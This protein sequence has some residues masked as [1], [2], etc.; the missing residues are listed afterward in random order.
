MP[1][2][3]DEDPQTEPRRLSV[4]PPPQPQQGFVPD[5][6]EFV[7]DPEPPQTSLAWETMKQMGRDFVEGITT[8]PVGYGNVQ[9]RLGT[10]PAI[11]A[12]GNP[13]LD[14]AIGTTNAMGETAA[15]TAT[16]M[17]AV[18]GDSIG[19]MHAANQLGSK[20]AGVGLAAAGGYFTGDMTK[21]AAE[22]AGQASVEAMLPQT[23][24]E[25]AAR[26]I[27][28]PVITS[29]MA[30]AP[31]L[32]GMAERASVREQ[33]VPERITPE[34]AQ[35]A[36]EGAPIAPE[37]PRAIEPL[38]IPESLRNVISVVPDASQF[39]D[40]HKTGIAARGIDPNSVD[41]FWDPKENK[42]ILNESQFR[43]EDGSINQDKLNSK[44]VH[45]TFIH[46]GLRPALG[47][48]GVAKLSNQ[49]WD[50]L[51]DKERSDIAARNGI[52]LGKTEHVGEEWLGY[53]SERVAR[54]G[55]TNTVWT[56]IA[57]GVRTALRALG[58]D[59]KLS[60]TE[61]ASYIAKGK[62]GAELLNKQRS[63][64]GVDLA[65]APADQ[66]Y[67]WIGERLDPL[68]KG[69]PE[70]TPALSK[71]PNDVMMSVNEKK[72]YTPD[73]FIKASMG[74]T[75]E[76]LRM[77]QIRR[78]GAG[79]PQ[80]PAVPFTDSHGRTIAVGGDEAHGGKPFD[81]WKKENEQWGSDAEI[82]KWRKWY[83]E[84][85]SEFV[86]QY[87]EKEA[88]TQMI[89][90]LASQQSASPSG[91]M[92]NVFR[93]ED[94]LS[95]IGTG[96]KGGLPDAKIEGILTHQPPEKGFG[97]KLSDF[98]DS[99]LG[100]TTRSYMGDNP[101]GGQ[102]F[103]ADIW[104]GRD[105]GHIDQQTI[106]RLYEM[107]QAGELYL[108][109][110]PVEAKMTKWKTIKEGDKPR[111]VP[112]RLLIKPQGGKPFG[113]GIDMTSAPSG[114]VYEGTSE[115][116]HRLT[117]HLNKIG[118]KGGNWT[119]KEVQ[120]VGW[121]RAIRQYGREGE[122]VDTALTRN[123][124]R[125]YAEVNYGSGSVLP[126]S[127]P[128]FGKLPAEAQRTITKEAIEWA[129]PE[130][131]KRIGGSLRV[132]QI[133][134]GDGV[135]GG[136]R[137]P[138][139]AIEVIGS[140]AAKDLFR[141]SL[142]YVGEQAA[143]MGVDFGKGGENSR[144]ISFGKQDGSK[145]TDAEIESLLKEAEISGLSAHQFPGGEQAVITGSDKNYTPKPFTAKQAAELAEKIAD[146]SERHGIAVDVHDQAGRVS[147]DA[148]DYKANP[149]GEKYLDLLRRGGI[150]VREQSIV[151]FRSQYRDRL[152][153]LIDRARQPESAGG[154]QA[155]PETRL[156][157]SKKTETPPPTGWV[158]PNGEYAGA[159]G[160][161]FNTGDWHGGHLQANMD[162]YG[163]T[164]GIKS[165]D[166]LEALRKGFVRLR[167]D[168]ATGRLGIEGKVGSL[169]GRI[170]D[171]LSEIVESNLGK[172]DRI[173][174]NLFNDKGAVVKQAGESLFRL[175]GQDKSQAAMDMLRLSVEK[176][177]QLEKDI[178]SALKDKLASD[179]SAQWKT[180]SYNYSVK[181]DGKSNMFTYLRSQNGNGDDR[182]FAS[183]DAMV[184]DI[185]A[186]KSA[187]R[188]KP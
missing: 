66:F 73:E 25:Q 93:V 154:T 110:K 116:G 19:L 166:R 76:N 120:A 99:G 14:A 97:A 7:P 91:G 187:S 176:P 27:T 1:F 37:A 133:A 22:Q 68:T 54:E 89:A 174:I 39:A 88:G 33:P 125:V 17:N 163:K 79:D 117:D 152:K 69:E 49:I 64:E 188:G 3:L 59:V 16:P 9:G 162:R 127:L 158:L 38:P 149:Q 130:I 67:Q 12:S 106:S 82:A 72:K 119:P 156:S 47:E 6:G 107:A 95:G 142:A 161:D 26:M 111:D 181:R 121:M 179:G 124:Q 42:V 122:S 34:Q 144:V 61:I 44:I 184:R 114:T 77:K 150:G 40:H 136:Q 143:T 58:I 20:A 31:I 141:Q 96:K 8:P 180:S 131:A 46:L 185:V 4:A 50:S 109:G 10:I 48:E 126:A 118:W 90:W 36:A 24:T 70:G 51:G 98:V 56:K 159:K 21:A 148:N 28:A 135:W 45:E 165:D 13:Y 35:A 32:G 115:W 78:A 112:T 153:G 169:R 102:P 182:K 87:G 29:A 173:D 85:H 137:A 172:L 178:R 75:A 168:G 18:L 57:D 177:S 183:L 129:V 55:K 147:S 167:Y 53:E 108:N 86:K 60:D 139:M 101:A 128:E 41:G 104:T 30:A 11:P 100:K 175:S 105:R 155:A 170:L 160:L 81:L 23:S 140:E 74:D 138:S 171:K 92:G 151:D 123:T 164:F 186:K 15:G 83:D 71:D 5:F 65:N 94:R 80:N 145:F 63:R 134:T 113:I 103:V 43:N 62:Q 157:V 2:I 84:L 52:D 132:R 146:W